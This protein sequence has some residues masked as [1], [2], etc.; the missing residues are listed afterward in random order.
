M[1]QPIQFRVLVDGKTRI[2][3]QVR[4][5]E[6]LKVIDQ[7]RQIWDSHEPGQRLALVTDAGNIT[8]IHWRQ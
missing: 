7:I 8:S 1:T 3:R 4:P 2:V 5:T 6:L